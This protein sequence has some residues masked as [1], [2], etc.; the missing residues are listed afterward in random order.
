M[1]RVGDVD[2]DVGQ[3][4]AAAESGGEEDFV[5]GVDVAAAEQ[6]SA[7][8]GDRC[9]GEQFGDRVGVAFIG[10]L[11]VGSEQV[12][13]VVADVA[14]ANVGHSTH[15]SRRVLQNWSTVRGCEKVSEEASA[16]NATNG[17]SEVS[18]PAELSIKDSTH[19]F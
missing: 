19:K 3:Q 15:Q 11:C 13:E 6:G 10:V 17:G 2:D 1:L 16:K 14:G 12:V 4:V 9:V 5:V 8:E 18:G 7:G